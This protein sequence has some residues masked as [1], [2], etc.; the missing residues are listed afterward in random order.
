MPDDKK[1]QDP[2]EKGQEDKKDE[3]KDPVD[4][5]DNLFSSHFKDRTNA[6]EKD[7][8]GDKE[9]KGEGPEKDSEGKAKESDKD[10]SDEKKD[11]ESGGEGKESAG[12]KSEKEG[13]GEEEGSAKEEMEARAKRLQKIMEKTREEEEPP[14]KKTKKKAAKKVEEEEDDDEKGDDDEKSSLKGV[15]LSESEKDLLEDMPEI[16]PIVDKVIKNALKGRKGESDL[17]PDAIQERL[18]KQDDELAVLRTQVALTRLVPDYES[19]VFDGNKT[20]EMEDGTKTRKPNPE[21][22]EEW[23]PKQPELHQALAFSDNPNDTASVL[24]AYKEDR[25]KQKLTE[26]DKA[27]KEKL[28]KKKDLHSHSANADKSTKK[29]KKGVDEDD[30]VGNFAEATAKK[31]KER[32]SYR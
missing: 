17:D 2:E 31:E 16:M 18:D 30:Y 24:R 5:Q 29:Q 26:K 20:V 21:F 4:E 13:E 8:S 11:E 28:D 9:D 25:A 19:I 27:D 32:A 23:L 12:K 14:P 15:K 7:K 22:W 10:K 6:I 1:T 3:K